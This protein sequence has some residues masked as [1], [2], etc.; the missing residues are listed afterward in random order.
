[1]RYQC[2]HPA[3]E[4]SDYRFAPVLRQGNRSSPANKVL[5]LQLRVVERRQRGGI[6][7]HGPELFGEIQ[8]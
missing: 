2:I 3:L 6:R 1:M 7:D 8:C 4:S 5:L